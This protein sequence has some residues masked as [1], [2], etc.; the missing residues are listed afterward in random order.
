MAEN[1]VSLRQLPPLFEKWMDE[2]E[3]RLEEEQLNL[4]DMAYTAI[5]HMEELKKKELSMLLKSGIF[6]VVVMACAT[7]PP[8][9]LRPS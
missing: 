3:V 8:E 2:D 5:G 7:H 6:E 9:G 4:V 1:R